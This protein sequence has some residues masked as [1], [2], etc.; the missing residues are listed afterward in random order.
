MNE[1]LFGKVDN[2]FRGGYKLAALRLINLLG[3]VRLARVGG[4]S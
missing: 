3:T 4:E 1:V 2:F